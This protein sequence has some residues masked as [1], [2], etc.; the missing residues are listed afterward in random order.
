MGI[1]LGAGHT[2]NPYPKAYPDK[3]LNFG[4]GL[5]SEVNAEGGLINAGPGPR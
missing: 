2:L 5:P 1:R 4:E 3:W